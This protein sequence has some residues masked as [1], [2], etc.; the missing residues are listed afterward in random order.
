M[1]HQIPQQSQ[2]TEWGNK[3]L[4]PRPFACLANGKKVVAADGMESK[5]RQDTGIENLL[6]ERS[7]WGEVVWDGGG[8]RA[9]AM[10]GPEEKAKRPPKSTSNQ[11][12]TF[13]LY[14]KYQRE[15]GEH[16][17]FYVYLFFVSFRC[18]SIL[19][20]LTFVPCPPCSIFI[21]EE[22]WAGAMWC[23]Q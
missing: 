11:N 8:A 18:P 22:S 21:T 20:Q 2:M 23:G 4:L 14:V 5:A 1:P 3:S 17:N 13:Y 16:K 10:G 6:R 19:S 9:A 15:N 12:R 7:Y